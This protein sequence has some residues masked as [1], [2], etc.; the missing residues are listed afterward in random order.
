MGTRGPL[1]HP[2]GELALLQQGGSLFQHLVALDHGHLKLNVVIQD[3]GAQVATDLAFFLQHHQVHRGGV[4]LLHPQGE[5]TGG[6]KADDGGDDDQAHPLLQHAEDIERVFRRAHGL[7]GAAHALLAL[8]GQFIHPG[9]Q[10]GGHGHTPLAN[11]AESVRAEGLGAE[12]ITQIF[13]LTGEQGPSQAAGPESFAQIGL[14]E[15]AFAPKS[16]KP[17]HLADP[18][19]G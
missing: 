19:A 8:K 17:S 18:P 3:R 11:K 2:G 15:A 10:T 16:A 12:I 13:M 4:I 5:Q 6:N 14:A 1:R 7:H 9:L